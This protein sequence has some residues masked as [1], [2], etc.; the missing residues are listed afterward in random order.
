ML[1]SKLILMSEALYGHI[2]RAWKAVASL[3]VN[4]VTH[5]DYAGSLHTVDVI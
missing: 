3:R 2:S 4:I 1:I 5:L